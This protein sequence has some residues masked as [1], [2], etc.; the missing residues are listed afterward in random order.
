MLKRHIQTNQIFFKKKKKKSSHG[1]KY[2]K[3][4][5]DTNIWSNLH[6]LKK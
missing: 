4:N 6:F 5:N 3:I 1:F 2:A